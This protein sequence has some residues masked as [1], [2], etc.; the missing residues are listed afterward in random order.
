M[1]T[2]SSV[3]DYIDCYWCLDFE[4]CSFEK[5]LCLWRVTDDLSAGASWIR[6]RGPSPATNSTLLSDHTRATPLGHYLLMVAVQEH[7][8]SPLKSS[9]FLQGLP[10]SEESGVCG[11]EFWYHMATTS[12]L[13]VTLEREL[14]QQVVWQYCSPN[15]GSMMW[16]RARLEFRLDDTSH[17]QFMASSTDQ[18]RTTIALDDIT[19]LRCKGTCNQ[20]VGLSAL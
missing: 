1:K 10:L 19:Y 9:A 20:Y 8:E 16:I 15:N 17:V 11:I 13:T 5:D 3:F 6:W 4:T 12:T 18:N 2:L 7:S 14:D